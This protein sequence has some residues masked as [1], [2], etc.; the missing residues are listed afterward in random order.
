MITHINEFSGIS[1]RRRVRHFRPANRGRTI[2]KETINNE[3]EE[4]LKND[5]KKSNVNK[6]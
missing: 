3:V 2:S 5:L 1:Q 6:C 4:L